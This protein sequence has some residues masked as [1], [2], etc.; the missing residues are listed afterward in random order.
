MISVIVPI[1][2]GRK[3]RRRR[4]YAYMETL[5]RQTYRDFETIV[6]EQT[7]D[8][9]HYYAGEG[10][11]HIKLTDPLKRG[12]NESWGYNVGVRFAR[13]E[14]L[15]LMGMDFVFNENFLQDAVDSMSGDFMFAC[16][17]CVFATQAE[18]DIFY[19]DKDY[20]WLLAQP[21]YASFTPRKGAAVGICFV[22]KD[23]YFS[24][25]GGWVENYIGWGMLD[26]CW[27]NRVADIE[28]VPMTSLPILPHKIIHLCHD[29]ERPQD[30]VNVK[31]DEMFASCRRLGAEKIRE[32]NQ[33]AG[34]VNSPTILCL[35]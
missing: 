17:T 8:G 7:L 20:N 33:N 15:A 6:V 28:G 14:I 23:A 26:K 27:G 3:E 34:D 9:G 2:G 13:G 11:R 22:K 25:Y 18:T 16:D 4:F 10:N 30:L 1:G 31:C 21:G 32:L 5:A 35:E 12:F 29:N 19:K 24:K